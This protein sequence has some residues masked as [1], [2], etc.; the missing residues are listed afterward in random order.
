[1]EEA[2]SEV[3]PQVTRAQ[4]GSVALGNALEFYDFMIFSFFAI[5]IGETF[6]PSTNPVNS[7]LA[8]LAT[9]GAGFLTRPLGA[10]AIGRYGDR[11]GRKP[12]MLLSFGLIGVSS[13][14]LALIPSYAA[15]GIAAPV[16]VIIGRLVQGFALG[17]EVGPSTAFL[18][19]C[20]PIEKRGRYIS[21]QF[22]SQGAAI[23]AS[24][25]VGVAVAKAFGDAG[26]TEYGWRIALALGALIVPVGL[27]LRRSL[28]ETLPEPSSEEPASSAP[29]A[30]VIVLGFFILLAGTIGTYVMTYLTTY[31]QSVLGLP[32]DISLGATVAGGLAY[33]LGAVAGGVAAD[34]IARRPVMLVPMG[35]SFVLILP[36]F[37]WL[38]ANPS[39]AVLYAV[40]F[41]LRF[42]LTMGMTAG[43]IALTEGLPLRVRAGALSLVYAVAI[44]V[45]GGSTQFIIAWLTDATGDPMAP[46]WYLLAA[47]GIGL[48]AMALMR[49]SHPRRTAPVTLSAA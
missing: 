28:V 8:A 33:M 16:L 49:E 24:G 3:R 39:E 21:L 30:R 47:T 32:P 37:W 44:S 9:F 45:F 42:I 17:G 20:A 43:F 38:N 2:R 19:E 13:L 27:V 6:F 5:Q 36:S 40:A 46:A 48:V 35:L 7:L 4:L 1:M 34:R 26:L 31:A 11:V 29:Y 10:W 14:A 18:A 41:W 25:I 22:I 23:L 12:A 15:I